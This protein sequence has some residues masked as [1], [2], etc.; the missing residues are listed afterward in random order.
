MA[1]GT[2]SF[3]GLLID[4]TDLYAAAIPLELQ[5]PRVSE[6]RLLADAKASSPRPRVLKIESSKDLVS[7]GTDGTSR[8]MGTTDPRRA[9]VSIDAGADKKF[10]RAQA[11][12]R[13]GEKCD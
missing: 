9:V 6:G 1:S 7:F 5:N 10:M 3:L 13:T 11:I 2:V 4:S 8:V 12:A